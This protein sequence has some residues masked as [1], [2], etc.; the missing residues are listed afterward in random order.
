VIGYA[1]A[2]LAGV[3]NERSRVLTSVA[4]GGKQVLTIGH[5][6]LVSPWHYVIVFGVVRLLNATQSI[7]RL[8][9]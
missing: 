5:N 8:G 1:E 6:I 9:S 3:L 4:S 7:R 2:P